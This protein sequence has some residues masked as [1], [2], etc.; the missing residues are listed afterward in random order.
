MSKICAKA[1]GCPCAENCPGFT[2]DAPL[3]YST[4]T[5]LPAPYPDGWL[6]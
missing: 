3:V 6:S 2:D 5:Y 4:G 1:S